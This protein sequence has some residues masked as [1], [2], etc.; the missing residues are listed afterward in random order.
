MLKALGQLEHHIYPLCGGSGPN[1]EP[2][3]SNLASVFFL[4]P[5]SSFIESYL[6]L[7]ASV[8]VSDL[9]PQRMEVQP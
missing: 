3:L 5:S 8:P 1:F 9:Y 2:N 4:K 7:Q 6:M